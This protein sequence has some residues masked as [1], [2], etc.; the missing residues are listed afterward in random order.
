MSWSEEEHRTGQQAL[1][2]V[3]FALVHLYYGW[4]AL[5]DPGVGFGDVGLYQYWAWQGLEDGRWPVLDEPWV[6][7]ALA[8]VP[9]TLAG[10]VSTVD[11]EP[12]LTA[13]MV[14]VSAG[15]ACA[16]ALLARRSWI[17]AVWWMC[18]LALLG[19]VAFGRVD[20]VAV[21]FAVCGL[22]L[23][24]E[25]PRL[26]AMLLTLGA[27]V[28]VA[29]GALVLPLFAVVRERWRDVVVPAAAACA[30]V[31]GLVAAGG[32][33]GNV[34]SFVGAQ[35]AR[36]LQMESVTA[37]PWVLS[38]VHGGPGRVRYDEELITWEVEG[39]GVATA[40]AVLD[41]LLPLLVLVLALLL[42]RARHTVVETLTWG[43][44]AVTL[45]LLVT[46]K[47]GS[48]QFVSWLAAPVAAGL[49]AWVRGQDRGTGWLDRWGWPLVAALTL[50]IAALTHRL[51]PL[52]YFEL[53]GGER[54]V[55]WVLAVRNALEVGLFVLATWRLAT[56]RRAPARPEPARSQTGG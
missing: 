9:V 1:V 36:G 54:P 20:A 43:S 34:A 31:V 16:T 48:P 21:P 52:G 23:A 37:T 33:L 49:L 3:L 25:R 27:W 24:L 2:L 50:L 39:P 5:T 8:L 51:I 11:W 6:Y 14:L 38:W 29:P 10:L 30:A 46:N 13:W 7:P 26:A 42:W 47:V 56:A 45:C 53:V 17:A 12:Y 28:K 35:G 40:A 22:L 55:A 32:G 41:G 44:L 4:T 18:F 19:P 15:N